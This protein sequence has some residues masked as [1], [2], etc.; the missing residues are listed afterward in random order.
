MLFVSKRNAFAFSKRIFIKYAVNVF[1][2]MQQSKEKKLSIV[3]TNKNIVITAFKKS[4][5]IDGY[6]LRLFNN[7]ETQAQTELEINGLKKELKFGRYEF[8]TVNYSGTLLN[9]L[10]YAEI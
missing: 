7:S 6:I 3:I 4:E 9:E 5:N 2:Y 8:K 1:P 10:D